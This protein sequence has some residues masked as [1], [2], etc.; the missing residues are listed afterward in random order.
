ML[1]AV[2]LVPTSSKLNINWRQVQ[3]WDSTLR[4]ILCW[5]NLERIVKISG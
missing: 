4:Y 1:V 2:L 5:S 3:Q